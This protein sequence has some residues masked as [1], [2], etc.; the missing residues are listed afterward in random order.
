LELTG[1]RGVDVTLEVGGE[2]TMARS[3]AAT[4]FGGLVALIG[5][6]ARRAEGSPP[7]PQVGFG[8]TASRIL[9]GSRT[10]FEDMNRALELRQVRPVIDRVFPFA[11]AREAY[12]YL[13]SQAHFGKVVI[14]A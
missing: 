12:R 2:G 3:L 4:R 1:G 8:Q 9:V 10:M 6:L 13:E 5:G 14:K 11:A 7:A